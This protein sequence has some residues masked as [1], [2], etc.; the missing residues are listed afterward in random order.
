ML[1]S[2]ATASLQG[3]NGFQEAMPQMIFYLDLS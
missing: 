2:T 1:L 3:F